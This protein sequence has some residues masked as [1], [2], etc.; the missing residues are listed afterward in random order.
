ME[1]IRPARGRARPRPQ[2]MPGQGGPSGPPPRGPRPSAPLAGVTR[3]ALRPQLPPITNVPR[4][5]QRPLPGVDQVTEGVRN[6]ATGDVPVPI[7]RGAIRGRRQVET[8]HFR[9]PRP[10]SSLGEKGKKGSSGTEVKLLAN[11]F[12]ITSY[13]TWCLY[14]YRV[15]FDPQEDRLSTKKGLLAQHKDRFGGYLFD[16][17]MLFTSV[18]LDPDT[19]DLTSTRRYD[20]QMFILKIKFTNSIEPGDY[21]YIQVFNLLL[22]NCIRHLDLKLIGRNFYDPKAII[23]L[24]QYKIQLWPGYETSIAK[25]ENDIL[26][27]AEI[28]TKVM[29]QETVLDFFKQCAEDRNRNPDWMITFKNGVIGTTVMTKYNN[30][31]Y[32]I[33]DID[34]NSDP[35]STFSK[36]DGSKMSYNQYYQ[37]KWNITI[38]GGRQPMLISKNKKSV[39]QFGGEEAIVYLV[40]ELCI[41]TGITDKMR[42]NLTLMRDM[43]VHTRVDPNERVK[44]LTNFAHRLLSTPKSVEELKKWNLTLGK[45]LVELSGRVLP[46]EKIKSNTR[47]YDGA[48]EADWTKQLRFLPMYTCALMKCW[49]IVAPQDC[50]RDV[51]PFAVNLAKAAQGM[52]FTLPRPIL[53]PMR[54]ARSQSF[55]S[56]LEQVINE[57]NPTMI[58]CVIPSARGDIYSLIKRKLCVDR[59]VPSQ[60]VLLKNVQKNN[61]SV[62]TKIAIQVNCKIGGAPWLVAIPKKGMMIVGFDVCHDSQK[63][64][65]SYGALVAT[66]NDSHTSY[67]SCVEP[68][69]SGEELSNHFAAGISKALAKYKLKNNGQLPTSIVIYRDGVGEGQIS[70]VHK[71]EIKLLRAATEQFYGPVSVPLAFILVTKRISAR[72]FTKQGIQNPQAG[73]IVDSVVTDPTKYDFF[74]VSQH[75]R[76]GTVTP[77]HY[78]VIEDTL[79]LPPDIVQRLT[80]KLCHMYYNWSGTVRVP[81]PCQLAH[82]LAFLTGQ[83][84]RSA[85]NTG[86]DEL[87]YFL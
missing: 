85:P 66:M 45:N 14:Q 51:Q 42:N 28:S 21:A 60:V 61:M 47:D 48:L 16:G 58:L 55:L 7:G 81:A 22:R 24:A 12:P 43:A 36:K 54:D 6:L 37:E 70:Y 23:D 3:P 76:L 1:P 32:R 78:T 9:A 77:T 63:K 80:Y 33:D 35:S 62:V 31:T 13:T 15:D 2:T 64:N 19:F 52:S 82:K 84:L 65:I 8:E 72:F 87:L 18:K 39:R 4:P 71:T 53:I 34:E 73:T 56:S 40:P 41:M 10:E 44:R 30:E 69:N 50:I 67:F 38:R 27:C 20:D 46:P 68:H 83:T 26:L 75:V 86:L 17:S 25:Y 74:L 79:R 5:Q 29:R 49:V 59:A 11:Y 57:H